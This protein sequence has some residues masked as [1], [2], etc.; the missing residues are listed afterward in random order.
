MVPYVRHHEPL[1]RISVEHLADEVLRW[2]RNESWNQVI[3]IKD[4]LVELARVRILKWKVAACHRVQD[5]ATAPNVGVESM[6]PLASDHL[7]SCVARTTTGSLESVLISIHVGEAEIHNF[8]IVLVIKEQ[9]FWLQVSVTYFDLVNVLNSRDDL[10]EKPARLI[11]LQTFPLD[12]VV[13]Q[14]SSAGILHDEK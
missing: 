1:C 3:A 8:D 12:D 7:R 2:L 9:I 14:L 6:I 11:L 5:D 13:E 4:L 10:L